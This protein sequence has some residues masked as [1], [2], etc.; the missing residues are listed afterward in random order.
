VL[1]TWAS[2]NAWGL[3]RFDEAKRFGEEAVALRDD[4]GFY[5]F[6][7]AFTDLATVALHEGE[8]DRAVALVKTGAAHE[9]D[10]HDRLCLASIPFVLALA[11]RGEEAV[12][13]AAD[14]MAAVKAAGAPFSVVILLTGRGI[15][16][17]RSDPTAAQAAFDEA[18]EL[19]QRSGNRL[20]NAM[21][22]SNVA[23]LQAR[24]GEPKAALQILL[25]AL[26]DSRGSVDRGFLANVFAALVV[27][28]ERLGRMKPAAILYGALMREFG[29]LAALWELPEAS[30][31]VRQAVGDSEFERLADEVSAMPLFEVVRYAESEIRNAMTSGSS[32]QQGDET[33]PSR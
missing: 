23:G 32:E 18:L 17:S 30:A 5:P 22:L 11:G 3:G 24:A 14:A 1:L 19:S 26:E 6:L 15:A 7:W 27:I 10:R 29:T 16:L 8:A 31:R 20:L 9:A 21:I 12:A 25:R 13:A 33:R 2:S 28:F 4:P